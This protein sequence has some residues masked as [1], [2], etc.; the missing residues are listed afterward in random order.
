M[1]E[2]YVFV[3]TEFAE[4]KFRRID[5]FVQERIRSKLRELKQH[6]NIGSVLKSLTHFQYGTHRLRIGQYRVILKKVS[7]YRYFVVDIG[8]RSD[9]YK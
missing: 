6:D 9:I 3:F 8:N 1:K 4:R 7:E 2:Q 5:R